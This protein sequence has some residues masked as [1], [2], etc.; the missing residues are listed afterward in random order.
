[1]LAETKM[2]KNFLK[3]KKVIIIKNSFFFDNK[4]YFIYQ[5]D[6]K[7]W[8][9]EDF[10]KCYTKTSAIYWYMKSVLNVK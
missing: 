5:D 8:Y 7:S 2:Y 1:M 10:D 4:E 9:V 6:D 3:E